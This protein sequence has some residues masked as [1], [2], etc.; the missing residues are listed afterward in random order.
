MAQ[1]PDIDVTTISVGGSTYTVPFPYQNKSE[2][3]VEV[4][5]N[6]PTYN[7]INDGLI[8]ITPAPAV[9]SNVRRYRD[10]SALTIRH[11][12]RNGV[13]FTPKNIAENNDQLLF[14]VQEAVNT[15]DT[16]KTVAEG[17]QT[18]AQTAL[19]TATAAEGTAAAASA[20]AAT[21]ITTANNAAAQAQVA[22]D[23]ADEAL[24][25]IAAAG[26]ASFNGRSGV[27]VPEVGDYSSSQVTHG[28][29]SVEGILN[30]LSTLLTEGPSSGAYDLPHSGGV[31]VGARIDSLL[32][33]IGGTR[34]LAVDTIANLRASVAPGYVLAQTKG[35]YTFGDSGAGTYYLDTTDTS[36]VDNGF[37]II[38][39][40]LGRRWRLIHDGSVHVEQA[41]ARSDGTTAMN[42][43]LAVA[44]GRP[45]VREVRLGKGPYAMSGVLVVPAG[46]TIS[47]I[48]GAGST[49]NT[50]GSLSNFYV[51]SNTTVQGITF[52]CA[53]QTSG[54]LF[55]VATSVGGVEY[56]NIRDIITY[57]CKGFLTDDN[58]PSYVATNV[59]VQNIS[60]RALKGHG[61]VL[62]DVFAF[63]ECR[64]IAMDYLGNTTGQNFI[65]FDIAF[66]EGCMFDNCETTGSTGIVSG[67]NAAQIGFRFSNC[68][69]VYLRR[70][71]SD[72][73]G[74]NG[75]RFVS[76]Q[77]VRADL[78]SVS[79]ADDVGFYATSTTDIQV[80]NL[81]I[82][83]RRGIAGATAGIAGM[84]LYG[85]TRATFTGLQV[86][87]PTGNG[88]V[89]DGNTTQ[90]LVS[91]GL[92]SGAGAR[93]I[94]TG[95]GSVAIFT[96]CLTVSNV[97]GNY[98][99]GTA[100]DHLVS[101]QLAS[102]ALVNATGP[103]SG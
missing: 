53:G 21:A 89:T 35:Y 102:G 1:I 15:A 2:V 101:S 3:V 86:I 99:L 12:Y 80:T 10:T 50:L 5:G 25:A 47:G 7:W 28:A 73:A 33:Q 26:V 11:D 88:F 54:Y 22:E 20:A 46:K 91:N 9:G 38:V 4:D 90:V 23:K 44:L 17:L 77:Y 87:N 41:G 60:N 100:F 79:L 61:M 72:A 66:N 31:S 69:A 68:K 27:V 8:D 16:A 48:A 71:F 43:V 98:I 62:R 56:V 24:S 37:D 83:G 81:Y 58:S 67:T 97:G 42:Y 74:G 19:N 13:P 34:T 75:F 93:G 18:L 29:G 14:V 32:G 57:H 96:G 95:A 94:L 40:A 6:T 51:S 78:C 45:R 85:C 92:F 52:N 70:S 76:C 36:S 64:D 65:G 82:G 63:L 49:I 59:R 39:D 103:A 84:Y 55:N 30:Q